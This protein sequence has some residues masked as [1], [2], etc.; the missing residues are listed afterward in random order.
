MCASA[1]AFVDPI[2]AFMSGAC[3]CLRCVFVFVTL[4]SVFVLVVGTV[5]RTESN[6]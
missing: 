1:R 4:S 3:G 6:H 5:R 2:V